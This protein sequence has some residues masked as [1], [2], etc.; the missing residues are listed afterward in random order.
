MA[1]VAAFDSQIK[2]IFGERCAVCGS[3]RLS[4]SGN[5]EVEGAHIYPK[6][7][8]GRDVTQNGLSLCKSVIRHLIVA[9]FLLPTI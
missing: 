2:L 3:N 7:M 6:S 1:S 8:K 5:P 9:G 4:P